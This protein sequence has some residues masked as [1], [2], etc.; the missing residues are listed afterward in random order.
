MPIVGYLAG[1]LW[2]KLETYFG[3]AFSVPRRVKVEVFGV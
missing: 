2:R 3:A 1:K